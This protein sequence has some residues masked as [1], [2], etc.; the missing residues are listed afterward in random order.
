MEVWMHALEYSLLTPSP[1]RSI[2]C[3]RRVFTTLKLCQ[4]R[5]KEDSLFLRTRLK[6]NNAQDQV[7]PSY[8]FIYGFVVRLTRV[9]GTRAPPRNLPK[10]SVG[11]SAA[12][13]DTRT[14][15]VVACENDQPGWPGEKQP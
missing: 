13:P 15:C 10:G 6:R 12:V 2:S 1:N 9:A 14:H 5:C 11:M 8:T 4:I 3:M 7:C